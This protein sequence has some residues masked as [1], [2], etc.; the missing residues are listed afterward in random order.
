[1]IQSRRAQIAFSL[2]IIAVAAVTLIFSLSSSPRPKVL[3]GQLLQ[4]HGLPSHNLTF[5]SDI[6]SVSCASAGNCSAGGSY[7]LD[8]KRNQAFVVNETNGKWG[9]AQE[10]PGFTS[11]DAG[12]NTEVYAV[13]CP[14]SGNC[15]AGGSYSLGPNDTL[16]F[17]VSETNGV[18]GRAIEVP[19]SA[20]LDR[21]GGGFITSISC[22]SAGNCSAGGILQAADV[23]L[24]SGA[25]VVN[26]TNGKWG[27]AQELT[28]PPTFN[29]GA[30]G[31]DSISC[32]TISNCSAAGSFK[33]GPHGASSFVVRET[34]GVW[35]RIQVVPGLNALNVGVDSELRSISCAAS[36]DCTVVGQ[37]AEKSGYT[38]A[39]IASESGGVWGNA[40]KVPGLSHL[41]GRSLSSLVTVSCES[42]NNCSAGG[43]Y[44][45]SGNQVAFIVNEV[46]GTWDKFITI[47]G[48]RALDHGHTSYVQTISCSSPGNCGASG[49]YGYTSGAFLVNEIDGT[50]GSVTPIRGMHNLKASSAAVL[51]ISCSATTSCSAAGSFSSANNNGAFVVSTVP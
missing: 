21:G 26:E 10:V 5:G 1:M 19:G 43:F 25:F 16:V 37:Y 45:T 42:G 35:G 8:A 13:S 27:Q 48:L 41:N 4:V 30:A 28:G 46:N 36:G 20:V 44:Q 40:F 11:R 18:W 34:N 17:V 49:D 22:A 12:E 51:S 31:V 33:V 32:P 3:W 38:Q 29:K 15:S 23:S 24:D 7:A 39:F 50:W 9:A 14:T 47:A 2:L 6:F